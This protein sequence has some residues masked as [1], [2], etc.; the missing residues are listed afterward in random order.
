MPAPLETK[1]RIEGVLLLKISVAAV[2][3]AGFI[4]TGPVP[5]PALL[6]LAKVPAETVVPPVYTLE[7]ERSIEPLPIFTRAPVPCPAAWSP[8]GAKTV[9]S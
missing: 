8:K 1:E 6:L 5:S 3:V 4:I 7:A 9:R 2:P